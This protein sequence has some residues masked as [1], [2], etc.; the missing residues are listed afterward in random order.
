MRDAVCNPKNCTDPRR[1]ILP[2][3]PPC[4]RLK[5]SSLSRVLFG[6]RLDVLELDVDVTV[7]DVY[8]T[9]YSLYC[10]CMSNAIGTLDTS[11]GYL[12]NCQCTET[13]QFIRTD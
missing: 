12:W 4:S 11:H 1:L 10:L 13:V 8:P 7:L 6:T 5:L 9:D 3:S 2:F